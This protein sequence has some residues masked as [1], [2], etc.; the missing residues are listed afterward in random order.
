MAGHQ[1]DIQWLK[2]LLALAVLAAL[3]L[4]RVYV[5]STNPTPL[6]WELLVH[7]AIPSAIVVL[8]T[9]IVI[10]FVFHRQGIPD[11]VVD[12]TAIADAVIQKLPAMVSSN[13]TQFPQLTAFHETFRELEWPELISAHSSQIDIVVYYFDS[14][15]NANFDA[16]VNFL[17]KS[18]TRIRVFV[19]D[20]TQPHVL[21]TVH[22]LFGEFDENEVKSKVERTGERFAGALKAA[23]GDSSRLEFRYLP[24]VLNYAAQCLDGR[25]LVLS[26]FE[27]HRKQLI[28]SPALVVDLTKSPRLAAW[29]RKEMSGMEEHS[30]HQSIGS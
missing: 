15:V 13:T 7:D 19:S 9:G 18:D 16:L 21:E 30:K 20:P 12:S 1:R 14:W 8:A 3:A 17:R 10:Y 2:T 27:M 5:I 29:W 23:G 28:E 22:R 4:I 24:H 6:G 11:T 26:F 25:T